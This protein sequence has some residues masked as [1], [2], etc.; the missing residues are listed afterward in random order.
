MVAG[1]GHWHT[2]EGVGRHFGQVGGKPSDQGG[3][4][5]P[6]GWEEGSQV[7]QLGSLV[8]GGKLPWEGFPQ[9]VRDNP[10]GLDMA[11]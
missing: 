10:A 6:A 3:R 11:A 7:A 8:P 9:V 1:L 2:L 5:S 4:R